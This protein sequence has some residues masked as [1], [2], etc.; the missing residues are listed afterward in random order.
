MMF[1]GGT[2]WNMDNSV[3]YAMFE[4]MTRTVSPDQF[5]PLNLNPLRSV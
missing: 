2:P 1:P 4:T 3:A 5:N